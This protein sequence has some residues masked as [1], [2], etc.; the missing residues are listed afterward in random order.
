[1]AW[2]PLKNLYRF[3]KITIVSKESSSLFLQGI[4]AVTVAFSVL[5]SN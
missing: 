2:I 3:M 5:S 1:M 4:C